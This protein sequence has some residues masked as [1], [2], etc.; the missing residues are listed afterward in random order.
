MPHRHVWN[1]DHMIIGAPRIATPAISVVYRCQGCPGT[2]TVRAK[3]TI[4]NPDAITD[5][6]RFDKAAILTERR[7]QR[8]TP[9]MGGWPEG[10]D[11]TYAHLIGARGR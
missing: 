1:Y 10:A 7:R 3:V 2:R 11:E 9:E 6:Q 5:E 4:P 8:V